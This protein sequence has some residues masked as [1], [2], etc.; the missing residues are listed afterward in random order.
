MPAIHTT[1]PD[2]VLPIALTDPNKIVTEYESYTLIPRLGPLTYAY[3]RR[4][5]WRRLWHF[6]LTLKL[7]D[8]VAVHKQVWKVVPDIS[9]TKL[10]AVTNIGRTNTEFTADPLSAARRPAAGDPADVAPDLL[11]RSFKRLPGESVGLLSGTRL[12]ATRRVEIQDAAEAES[13]QEILEILKQRNPVVNKLVEDGRFLDQQGAIKAELL[14]LD[15]AGRLKVLLDTM[16]TREL[17]QPKGLVRTVAENIVRNA[18]PAG[19]TMFGEFGRL[20]AEDARLR[21]N[22]VDSIADNLR[23]LGA[24]SGLNSLDDAT[25][26]DSR[27]WAFL[28]RERVELLLQPPEYRGPLSINSVAPNSE[29]TI[30]DSQTI[31]TQTFD[32]S[33]T[34]RARSSG[35]NILIA[36]QIKEKLGTLYDYGS[37]L[38]Q[39]MSEQGYE[40]DNSRGEKRSIIEQTLSEISE[41]NA[42]K[43]ISVTAPSGPPAGRTAPPRARRRFPPP[44]RA[45]TGPPRGRSRPVRP[46]LPLTASESIAPPRSP[47]WPSRWYRPTPR[48]PSRAGLLRTSS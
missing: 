22:V 26:V 8:K 30:S 9:A 21:T 17:P 41:T 31:G 1:I 25:I 44:S 4:D 46:L 15:T 35:S 18:L 33:A 38:G 23:E 6:H 11:L 14:D 36:N 39:T 12:V 10:N 47:A 42:S 34:Q 45:G 27:E 43:T 48:R 20:I 2:A 37:N 3:I 29:L 28:R 40:R 24:F 19:D 32:I 7:L 13:Q 16:Y 5:A